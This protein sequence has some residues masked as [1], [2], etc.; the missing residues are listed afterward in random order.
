M[1]ISFDG[2]YKAR[3]TTSEGEPDGGSGGVM[4]LTDG[5]LCGGNSELVFTGRYTVNGD[6]ISAELVTRRQSVQTSGLLKDDKQIKFVGRGGLQNITCI[7][8]SPQL[9]GVE[10]KVMLERVPV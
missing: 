9:P 4:M 6:T 7:G 5:K 3:F 10:M 8:S 1:P 2:F